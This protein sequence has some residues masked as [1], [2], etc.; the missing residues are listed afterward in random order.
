MNKLTVLYVLA[1]LVTS[2]VVGCSSNPKQEMPEAYTSYRAEM[3]FDVGNNKLYRGLIVLNSA[4]DITFKVLSPIRLDRLEVSTCGRHEVYRDVDKTKPWFGESKSGFEFTYRY[5]PTEEESK[6]ACPLMFQAF[7]KDQ[8][9]AWGMM[10]FK[11]DQNLAA[12]MDCNGEKKEFSGI[13]ACQTKAGLE[14]K[15]RF[16]VPVIF[17]STSQCVIQSDD[18]MSFLVRSRG[19]FCKASFS[20]GAEFHDMILHGYKFVIIY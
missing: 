17:E 14:Q 10:F 16:A 2:S 13:S 5:I 3:A 8:Q 7:S 4:A 9:K 20:D 15:I 1:V 19:D 11:Q 6:G 12:N 18:Q